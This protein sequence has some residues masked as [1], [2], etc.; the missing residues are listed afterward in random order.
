MASLI[1]RV[2]L[3]ENNTR[4]GIGRLAWRTERPAA[5]ILL[6]IILLG[7]DLGYHWGSWRQLRP[8]F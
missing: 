1:T 6:G 3:G 8:R 4:H 7:R 5:I 2:D